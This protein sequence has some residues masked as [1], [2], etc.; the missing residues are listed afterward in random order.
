M[1]NRSRYRR[2]AALAAGVALAGAVL[3]GA[4]HTPPGRALA[5]SWLQRSLR[6]SGIDA[7]AA[8]FDYNILTLDVRVR[9]VAL[10]VPGQP[11]APFF[12][13]D[14][15]RV[16]LPARILIGRVAADSIEIDNP[17]VRLERAA[18]GATN[19]PDLSGGARAA[20][21]V[22]LD[23]GTV[24]ARRLD[25]AASDAQTNQ[26]LNVRS[27]SLELP[28]PASGSFGALTLDGR[29]AFQRGDRAIVIQSLSP[30]ETGLWTPVT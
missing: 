10:S 18:D 16:T 28:A 9:G 22:A 4:A 29:A 1:R 26:S 19:W 13:A 15:V 2:L 3:L 7:R 27:L 25:L 12:S 6:G 21:P 20:G 23:L 11:D 24:R 5:W 30:G 14:L 17:R 8:G